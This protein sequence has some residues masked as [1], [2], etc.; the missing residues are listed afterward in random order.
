MF[1]VKHY[2]DFGNKTESV[3]SYKQIRQLT[4]RW[5]PT[6]Q[7]WFEERIISIAKIQ[8]KKAGWTYC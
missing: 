5:W 7:S 6:R 3:M 8:R 1:L 2:D 4:R